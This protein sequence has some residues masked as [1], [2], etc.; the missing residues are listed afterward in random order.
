MKKIVQSL[1]LCLLVVCACNISN[2]QTVIHYWHFN[3]DAA[4][5]NTLPNIPPIDADTSVFDT[6]KA[7]IYYQLQA[8]TSS[9][10][11]TYRDFV[12]SPT[13]DPGDSIA[14]FGHQGDT[15][16]YAIRF[17]NP[18]D[19]ME[20]LFY[21][22]TANGSPA[23]Y[24]GITLKYATESTKNGPKTQ[25]YDYSTDSASTWKTTGLT[26]NAVSVDTFA[27]TDT[28]K[29]HIIYIG[30]DASADYNSKLV[31]RVRFGPNNT[32]GA[33]ND[34]FDNVTVLGTPG[35]ATTSV[36]NVQQN[37]NTLNCTLFPNPANNSISLN[38][39]AQGEK[40]YT[41][42]TS[43]G[44]KVISSSTD[45]K[46]ETIDISQ[47]AAGLYFVNVQAGLQ[48]NLMKFIKN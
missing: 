31:F 21:I 34:R 9:S 38:M 20:V 1:L 41:I 12:N 16:D 48:H 11:S 24:H 23:G 37:E 33:G 44:Q 47:F 36:N 43:A 39:P 18:C 42:Y 7:R 15:A 2:A 3:Q 19:S 30:F 35:T 8:G 45:N 10:Y 6:S 25:F 29:F 40:T 13:T 5:T 28:S 46:L 26:V 27:I 32:G 14:I 17:R 4:I 22:P